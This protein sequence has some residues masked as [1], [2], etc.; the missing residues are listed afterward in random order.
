MT[1]VAFWRIMVFGCLVV[2]LTVPSGPEQESHRDIVVLRAQLDSLT[3]VV[4][5]LRGNQ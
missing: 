5:S 2:L 3:V 4:D 1:P